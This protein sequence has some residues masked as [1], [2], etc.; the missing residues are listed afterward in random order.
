MRRAALLLSTFLLFPVGPAAAQE[1]KVACYNCRTADCPDLDAPSCDAGT[2]KKPSKPPKTRR[3]STTGKPA[4]NTDTGPRAPADN[5]DA[6]PNAPAANPDTDVKPPAGTSDTGPP[7]EQNTKSPDPV[8]STDATRLPAASV[9]STTGPADKAS[10]EAQ[11]GRPLRGAGIGL[12][13]SGVV[14][15]AAGITLVAVDRQYGQACWAPGDPTTCKSLYETIPIGG[16][17]L[18]VGAAALVGATA[19]F[20]IDVRRSHKAEHAWA[21]DIAPTA[22]LLGLSF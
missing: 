18:G 17:L 8:E 22:S 4:G 14:L 21:A 5:P 11:S 10:R 2:P 13:V 16:A 1:G 15:A 7:P 6:G 9:P 20:V 3:I 19:L 12:A